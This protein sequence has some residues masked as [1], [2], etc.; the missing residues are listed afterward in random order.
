[1]NI[2]YIKI[3]HFN[4]TNIAYKAKPNGSKHTNKEYD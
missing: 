2:S 4:K 1:M 3:E